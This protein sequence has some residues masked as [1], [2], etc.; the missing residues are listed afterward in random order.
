MTTNL[1][2]KQDQIHPNSFYK[3]THFGSRSNNSWQGRF[4]RVAQ[5]AAPVVVYDQISRPHSFLH[6][7]LPSFSAV[8]K[9]L[10]LTE[11]SSVIGEYH[12]LGERLSKDDLEVAARLFEAGAPEQAWLILACQLATP[13]ELGI[14]ISDAKMAVIHNSMIR[15]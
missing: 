4:Y 10:F 6:H 5:Y 13:R 3:L 7:L 15:K 14:S 12:S 1:L 2:E 11:S 8:S 9:G